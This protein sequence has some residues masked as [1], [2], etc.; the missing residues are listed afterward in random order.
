MSKVYKVT[1][2]IDDVSDAYY[3][4]ED[5][6]SCMENYVEDVTFT[7]ESVE[8]LDTT[9]YIEEV[10]DDYPWNHIDEKVRLRELRKYFKE[11]NNE[12]S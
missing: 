8:T 5:I 1:M 11:N 9:D 2:Y 3:G 10:E 4:I 6:K 12:N 7:F